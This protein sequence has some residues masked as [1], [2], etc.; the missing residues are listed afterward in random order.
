MRSFLYFRL[1]LTLLLLLIQWYSYRHLARAAQGGPKTLSRA[2]AALFFLFNLPLLVLFFWRPQSEMIPRWSVLSMVYPFY[3]WHFSF[4]LLSL[5]MLIWTILSTPVRAVI[6]IYRRFRREGPENSEPAEA[7]R[8]VFF[9]H[10]FAAMATVAL[11]GSSYAAYRGSSCQVTETAVPVRGLG[12]EFDGFT[13]TLIS[14]IHSGFFMA[15]EQMDEYVQTINRL[16]ADLIAV[17]GDFVNS[18][19]EEAYPFAE[20]FSRLEAPYG[21]YGVLGNHDYYTGEVEKVARVV[22]DCGIRLFRNSRIT[23]RRGDAALVLAGIDDIG[24]GSLAGRLFDLS[25]D[26]IQPGASTV[27]L[28]HRPYFFPQAAARGVDL[29]LSGH[30]HGGQVVLFTAGRDIIAPARVASPYVAGEYRIASSTMYVS[31][32]VGM[33]GIPIRINCPPEITRIT[34]RGV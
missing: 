2:I 16:G 21:V 13:I 20:S 17:P 22:E 1:V 7:G 26:G 18:A 4:T 23:L 19:L 12:R 28:C 5:C 10:G 27:M 6:W 8:R 24:S 25:L 14:D 33:V 9:R 34:L 11:A 30:T 29:I 31:R 3:A 15:K 32:G